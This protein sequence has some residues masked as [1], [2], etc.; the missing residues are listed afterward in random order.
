M[1]CF[2]FRALTEP[3][4]FANKVL[5]IYD[6]NDYIIGTFMYECLYGNVPYIFRN[7]FQRNADVNDHNL[8]NVDDLYVPYGRLDIRKYSMKIAGPSLWN[9]LPS[10]VK[11]SETVHIFKKNMKH[12]LTDRK[13]YI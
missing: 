11:N 5:N 6:I 4:Y 10:L 7:Y 12:Y 9:S 2:P 1:T 3:L 13:G 8:R